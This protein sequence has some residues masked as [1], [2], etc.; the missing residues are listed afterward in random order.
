MQ[1]RV[2]QK[3]FFIREHRQVQPGEIIEVASVP[4][5]SIREGLV[6]P[7]PPMPDDSKITEIGYD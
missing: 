6:E 3:C 2:L 5:K 7:Y 1:V 4:E